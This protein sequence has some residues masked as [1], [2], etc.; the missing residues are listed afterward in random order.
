MFT[1]GLAIFHLA[2]ILRHSHVRGVRGFLAV[3]GST[4]VPRHNVVKISR[5]RASVEVGATKSTNS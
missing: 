5:A 2:T 4:L 3:G 1:P